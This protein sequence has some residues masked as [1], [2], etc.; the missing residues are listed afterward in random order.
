MKQLKKVRF[1][2]RFENELKPYD[3]L[4]LLCNEKRKERTLMGINLVY[5]DNLPPFVVGVFNLGEVD[6][7]DF[8]RL[9]TNFDVLVVDT[10]V[11]YGFEPWVE[12]DEFHIPRFSYGADFGGLSWT[13]K[14]Q[15][16]INTNGR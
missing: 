7:K 1:I 5:E 4:V 8:K 3:R 14:V 2:K 15:I 10:H 13:G 6:K 11:E 9:L 16:A 12:K